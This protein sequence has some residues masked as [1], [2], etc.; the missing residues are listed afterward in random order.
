M[1][2]DQSVRNTSL[3][4]ELVEKTQSDVSQRIPQAESMQRGDNVPEP[5]KTYLAGYIDAHY[6]LKEE[7]Q[8]LAK[9]MQQ[10]DTELRE[11]RPPMCYECG[12]EL[13]AE[14]EEQEQAAME[15]DSRPA[16]CPECGE[17][18]LPPVK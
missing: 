2:A 16:D 15:N 6:E 8:T 9:L 4:S 5:M 13:G 12:A 1:D 10:F 7:L 11:C 18:P 3:P 17:N 14:W